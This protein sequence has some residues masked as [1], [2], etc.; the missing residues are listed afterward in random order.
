MEIMDTSA[1]LIDKP[2]YCAGDGGDL[3]WLLSGLFGNGRAL[4]DWPQLRGKTVLP[5]YLGRT[6]VWQLC[7]AWNIGDE[8]EVLLP[9]YH[10]GTEIDPFVRSRAN[11]IFYRV[12]ERLRADLEDI[13]RRVTSRTRLV[14]VTHYFGWP[15]PVTELYRWCRERS[16]KLVEDCALS[17]FSTGYE[18][19][20]GT[21]GDA[22]IFSLR[23]SLPIPDGGL[24]TFK[25]P[26]KNMPSL[27]S[28]GSSDVMRTLL[29]LMKI[30]TFRAA[31]RMGIYPTLRRAML[32][33]RARHWGPPAGPQEHPD[34]PPDYYLDPQVA[35]RAMSRMATA[36]ISRI[37]IDVCVRERRENYLTLCQLISGIPGVRPLNTDLP[38][39]VCPLALPALVPHRDQFVK[40]LN[41]HGIAAF[42]FWSGYHR[43]F[44]LADFPE[45]TWLKDN[46]LTLPI[47]RQL[48]PRHLK[49]IAGVVAMVAS[50]LA[51]HS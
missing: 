49:F 9:S 27:R 41:D 8:D 50:A 34:L 4:P 38:D 21:I 23:K 17:L 18:G 46:V 1:H 20:L 25:D 2:W 40:R 14:Y 44:N 5:C 7:R 42:P 13:R 36:M 45:A 29:S 15:Q 48:G 47:H 37:D 6:A 16:I 11:V 19:P 24:L 3:S 33:R 26:P 32:R 28:P 51:D 22:A 43:D 10:C 31:E 12:D 30:Q 35:E 39:G